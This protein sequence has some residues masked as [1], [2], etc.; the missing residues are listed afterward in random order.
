V[1][2]LIVAVNGEP[3][4]TA[5]DLTAELRRY[6]IG[7]TIELSIVRAGQRMNVSIALGNLETREL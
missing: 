5:R 1:G 4:R 6:A 2:Y 7:A 3:I